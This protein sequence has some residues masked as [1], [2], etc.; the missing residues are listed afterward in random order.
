MRVRV[1]TRVCGV[2]TSRPKCIFCDYWSPWNRGKR[3]C[4]HC[5]IPM[6]SGTKPAPVSVRV[7]ITDV[8]IKQDG[9]RL[10]ARTDT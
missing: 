10:E 9:W 3:L 2:Y 4:W 8:A 7:H 6:T 1:I 5:Y